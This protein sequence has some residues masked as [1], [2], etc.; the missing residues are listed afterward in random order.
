MRSHKVFPVLAA[1]MFTLVARPSLA[2]GRW[3]VSLG[4]GYSVSELHGSAIEAAAYAQLHPLLG[5]GLEAG[6]AHMKLERVPVGS[7]PVE[8]QGGI[9][10]GLASFTDGLT[11]N[12]GLFVGP[13]LRFGQQLYAV[14]SAGIYEFSDNNGAS[15]DTRWGGSAGLGLTGKGRFSPRAEIRYR[16]S[17]DPTIDPAALQFV[18]PAIPASRQDASAIVFTMG[19]DIR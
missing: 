2:D 5:L 16:W 10:S 14:A 3:V 15:L 18:G 17:P 9:G 12:R 8:P 1:L 13:A 19:I 4:A 6:M 11:R 7:F